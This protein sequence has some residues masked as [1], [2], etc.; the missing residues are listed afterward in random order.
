MN[1]VLIVP[2]LCLCSCVTAQRH[3]AALD[4]VG[5]QLEQA[6]SRAHLAEAAAALAKMQAESRALFDAQRHD[7]ALDR[8]GLQLEQAKSRAG[9]AEAE[10]RAHL[11]EAA[12]AKVEVDQAKKLAADERQII[13]T[14]IRAD[15]QLLAKLQA[16]SLS[17][18]GTIEQLRRAIGDNYALLRRHDEAIGA[19]TR[20]IETLFDDNLAE[21]LHRQTILDRLR[22][23]RQ[24]LVGEEVSP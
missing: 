14:R 11:A 3:E 2:L 1:R 20:D 21:E 15:E 17:T 18:E 13:V 4:R 6:E 5:F 8:V 9:L 10:S 12:L 7:V 24:E 23:E 22:Q 19:N 16:S